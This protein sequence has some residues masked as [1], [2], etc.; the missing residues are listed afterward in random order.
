[1]SRNSPRTSLDEWG[2]GR[3]GGGSEEMEHVEVH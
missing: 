3:V 2:G 1:M